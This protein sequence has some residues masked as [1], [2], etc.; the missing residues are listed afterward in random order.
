MRPMSPNVFTANILR[1]SIVAGLIF[2]IDSFQIPKLELAII[3]DFVMF[4]E[5][6]LSV[7]VLNDIQ[8]PQNLLKFMDSLNRKPAYTCS[9]N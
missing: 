4:V 2:G 9:F 8:I 7:L 5:S 1:A 3:Y 6:M